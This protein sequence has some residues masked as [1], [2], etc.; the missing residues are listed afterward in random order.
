VSELTPSPPL[1]PTPLS[2]PVAPASLAPPDG[3][4]GPLFGWE[5][6]RLNRSGHDARARTI[7]A[8]LLLV[9]LVGFLLLWFPGVGLRELLLG[10][11]QVL[12]INESARFAE[13]FS[14]VMI[15]AQ[16]AA[17][18][19]L[20]PAY[21]AGSLAEEKE[22][23]TYPFLII[24]LLSSRELVV[25]KF[26]GRVSFLWAVMFTGLPILAL[27]GLVGGVDPLFLLL[28]YVLTAGAVAVLTAGGIFAGV[29]A[30]TFR[31]A[32]F[33][34]YGLAA[35]YTFLGCG[36][37]PVLSPFAG[38][39]FAWRARQEGEWECVVVV[40]GYVALQLIA[41]A[42]LLTIAVKRIRWTG[43]KRTPPKRLPSAA[44]TANAM[45]KP[46]PKPT[47]L[48]SSTAVAPRPPVSDDDPF[49][50]KEEHVRGQT[51]TADDE[52]MR[53]TIRAASALAALVI[54]V[55][56]FLA[57]I[58]MTTTSDGGGS[59]AMAMGGIAMFIQLLAITSSACGAVCRERQGRTLESLQSL[60]VERVEL[61]WP[62]WMHAVRRGWGWLIPG[63]LLMV[64]G[65]AFEGL[66]LAAVVLFGY[67][68]ALGLF[69]TSWGLLYSIRCTA[70]TRAMMI[71][72]ATVGG[73]LLVPFVVSWAFDRSQQLLAASVMGVLT[74]GV[75][76]M[77]RWS[78]V[79]AKHDFEADGR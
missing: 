76:F 30:S 29:F 14:Q 60:P 41:I 79:R 26:L 64:S 42:I 57:V 36:L 33:Q 43:D 48:S 13:N 67:L 3:W 78:W 65:M 77:V 25:G 50:W 62:K 61:L 70:M 71:A 45:P 6:T 68:P 75:A 52:A 54:G 20:A 51:E 44:N 34:A 53:T 27:T 32:M 12:D 56:S 40:C 72:M 73:L 11:Q 35:L 49:T 38:L 9:V 46:L 59:L 1:P 47:T 69:A 15:Y 10:K 16:L 23:K 2:T 19:L 63:M 37:H 7:L 5:L 22:R 31:G 17:M 18:V 55:V 74:L 66:P 58:Q 39:F 4:V 28:A 21:A 8:F 24:S